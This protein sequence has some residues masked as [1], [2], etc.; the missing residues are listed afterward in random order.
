MPAR[1]CQWFTIILLLSEMSFQT[2]AAT[3]TRGRAEP[4][5]LHSVPATMFRNPRSL[6]PD[7]TLSSSAFPNRRFTFTETG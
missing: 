7:R 5:F 2:T 3:F 1:F 4:R 6:P